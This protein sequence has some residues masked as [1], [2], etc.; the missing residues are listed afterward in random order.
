MLSHILL[1]VVVTVLLAA[2]S[3]AWVGISRVSSYS[4]SKALSMGLGDMFKNALANDPNLPPA[5]NPGRSKERET[6]EVTFLPAKKTVVVPRGLPLAQVASLAKVTIP[7]KC[8]KGDCGTCT[9]NFEGRNIKACQNALP[10]I[11]KEKK[12]TIT[13][14]K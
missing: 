10:A 5:Q 4:R 2:P 9:V 6:V 1:V 8:K 3:N 12:Y 7:Y 13:I 11:G 14:P